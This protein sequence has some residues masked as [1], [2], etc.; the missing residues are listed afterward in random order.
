MSLAP[1]DLI[2]PWCS[3]AEVKEFVRYW[4]KFRYIPYTEDLIEKITWDGERIDSQ[5]WIQARLDLESW[6]YE[7][8]IAIWLSCDMDFLVD[9]HHL[10]MVG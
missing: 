5:N 7:E 9:R 6:G 10:N 2:A 4:H 1:A 3:N 8:M